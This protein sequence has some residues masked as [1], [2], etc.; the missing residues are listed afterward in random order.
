M[1]YVKIQDTTTNNSAVVDAT[2]ALAITSLAPLDVNGTFSSTPFG[3]ATATTTLSAVTTGTGT[4]VDLTTAKNDISMAI[5]VTGTVTAGTIALDTS[6]D[7]TNWVMSDEAILASNT[8][9]KLS[10]S[11]EAWRYA[12]GR[13]TANITGGATA[14][15]TIMSWG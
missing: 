10:N 1:T 3:D 11:G 6:H 13:V 4:T 14:T 2:G 5:L 8:N 15:C 12:R 9:T 7:G